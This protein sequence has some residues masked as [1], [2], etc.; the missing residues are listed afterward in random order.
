M[1][2][3]LHVL[4]VLPLG[5]YPP[6]PFHRRICEPKSWWSLYGQK[7]QLILEEVGIVPILSELF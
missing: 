1:R 3:Q 7:S 5:K 4:A 2:G 6:Y